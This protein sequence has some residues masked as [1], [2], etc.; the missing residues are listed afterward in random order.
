MISDFLREDTNYFANCKN[1][2]KKSTRRKCTES[3]ENNTISIHI[4]YLNPKGTHRTLSNRSA[5]R[6][7]DF[8]SHSKKILKG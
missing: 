1:C 3:M 4:L 6:N 7:S 5:E 8:T 2:R